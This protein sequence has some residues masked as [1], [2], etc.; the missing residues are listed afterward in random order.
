MILDPSS[1]KKGKVGEIKY[2]I[3]DRRVIYVVWFGRSPASWYFFACDLIKVDRMTKFQKS[4][5]SWLKENLHV[6]AVR[7]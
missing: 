3:P 2:L 4:F 5:Y 6:N 7:S 1:E